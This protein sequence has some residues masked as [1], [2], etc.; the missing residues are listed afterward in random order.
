MGNI[1][2]KSDCPI[3]NGKYE[4]MSLLGSGKAAHV[5]L[6]RSIK[7]PKVEVAIKI[8]KK[9]KKTDNLQTK[10]YARSEMKIH[11][12]LV[13][14]NVV[15]MIDFGEH[16]KITKPNRESVEELFYI[17]MEY[18]PQ[19]MLYDIVQNRGGLGE[20]NSRFFMSQILKSVNFMHDVTVVHRDLKLDNILVTE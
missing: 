9:N 2:D 20:D 6:A 8:I 14:E 5:Y 15:K 13:H 18:V 11:E 1:L 12:K 16:G 19:G 3:F 17:I 4:I 7:D 10:M